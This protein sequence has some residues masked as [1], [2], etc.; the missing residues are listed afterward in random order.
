MLTRSFRAA[1]VSQNKCKDHSHCSPDFSLG[2]QVFRVVKREKTVKLG[3]IVKNCS[4]TT[5]LKIPKP[6]ASN[7]ALC[8]KT[9]KDGRHLWLRK[10]ADC[11]KEVLLVGGFRTLWSHLVRKIG[12]SLNCW[13]YLN[14][15]FPLV[16]AIQPLFPNRGSPT[17][18]GGHLLLLHESD[19][20]KLRIQQKPPC[21]SQHAGGPNIE[22]Q[23][24]RG[25]DITHP[26]TA[27]LQ[28]KFL[29]LRYI[30]IDLPKIG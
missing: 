12:Y 3:L 8:P 7:N 11:H 27:P 30:C 14:H 4:C 23:Q 9:S 19:L 13:H 29:K 28:Q 20:V 15:W 17:V 10:R 24:Y 21:L 16:P 18:A 25:H 1:E 6:Q 5:Q 26:N 2:R 22:L